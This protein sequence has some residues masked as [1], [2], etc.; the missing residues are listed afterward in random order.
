[1]VLSRSLLWEDHYF[2]WFSISKPSQSQNQNHYK[3]KYLLKYVTCVKIS[4][5]KTEKFKVLRD[6]NCTN[7]TNLRNFK[8]IILVTKLQKLFESFDIYYIVFYLL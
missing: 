8:V 3:I 1:M 6:K 5:F 7:F 2:G 4:N